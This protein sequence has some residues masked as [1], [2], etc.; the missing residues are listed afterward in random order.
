MEGHSR[1][2]P[3]AAL[4]WLT[5]RAHEKVRQPQHMGGRGGS[6]GKPIELEVT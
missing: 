6:Q 5:K 4:L 3:Q 2:H 1:S